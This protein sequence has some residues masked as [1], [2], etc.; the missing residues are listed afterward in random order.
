[1]TRRF[2]AFESFLAE[3]DFDSVLDPLTFLPSSWSLSSKT[4]GFRF[5]ALTGAA[6]AGAA[7]FAPIEKNERIS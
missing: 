5:C 3:P 1:M 2:F 4:M 6:A 7:D